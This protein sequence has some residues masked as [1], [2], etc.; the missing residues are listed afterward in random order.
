MKGRLNLFS[1]VVVGDGGC[2][3]LFFMGCAEVEVDSAKAEKE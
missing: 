3:S 1:Q 2:H